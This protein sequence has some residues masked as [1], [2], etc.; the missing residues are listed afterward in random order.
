MGG[1][2]SGFGMVPGVSPPPWSLARAGPLAE[3]P[4]GRMARSRP[5]S[6]GSVAWML[7]EELGPLVPLA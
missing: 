1:L 7:G 5:T 6:P 2:T 3:R 4:E